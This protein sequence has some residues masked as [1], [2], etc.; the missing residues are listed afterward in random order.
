MLYVTLD[1]NLLIDLEEKRKGFKKVLEIL[2]LHNY[3]KIKI[4]IPAIAASEKL[5][6]AQHVPNYKLFE[7]YL[8]NLNIKNSEELM[9]LGIVGMCFVGHHLIAGN[10][11]VA[12]DHSIH[13]ILFPNVEPEYRD[14]CEKRNIKLNGIHRR[15]RN[16]KIDVQMLWCHIHYKKDI[17][18]TRDKNFKRKSNELNSK[19]CKVVIMT[20]HE[21][22]EYSKHLAEQKNE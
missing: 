14:F 18:I 3:G 11:L 12:L 1:T 22:L 8:S 10:E 16:A 20:P 6:D 13:R 2:D 9:P 19:V 15:W 21:F 4:C 7:E 5:L 17:F